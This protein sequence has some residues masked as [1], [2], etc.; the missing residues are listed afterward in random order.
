MPPVLDGDMDAI[1][2]PTDF[3]GLNYYSRSTVRNDPAAEPLRTTGVDEPGEYTEVG[4]L[5]AP[6]S[7]YDLL[8]RVWHDYRPTAIHIAENGAAFADEVAAGGQV[9]DER[10]QAY[11][12]D[13][14]VAA[15]R[16]MGE[17]VPLRGYFVWSLMDNFE[18]AE[19]YSKRFGVVYVDFETQE[20]IVKDSGH[21]YRGVIGTNEVS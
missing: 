16:A 3:L 13:H 8:T 15:A 9:H 21:W 10:R 17:G 6:E 2:V 7:L 20:R 4:W 19:G 12:R 14:F 5:V 1:A 11:L 18:W